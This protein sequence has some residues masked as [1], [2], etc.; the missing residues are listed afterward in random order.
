MSETLDGFNRIAWLYDILA[1]I[2]FGRSLERAERSLVA[3]VPHNADV[4]ILGGG[5]GQLLL[6]LLS[7]NPGCSVT[8]IE[9]SSAMIAIAKRR[10]ARRGTWKV[11]FFHRTALDLPK[12]QQFDVVV[13]NFFLD[14]FTA[15]TVRKITTNAFDSLKPDGLWL[16][17]DFVEGQAWWQRV[18]LKLMLG[19][20]RLTAR[21][22]ATHL[23]PWRECLEQLPLKLIENR[24]FYGGFV[25]ANAYQKIT[26]GP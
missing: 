10:L 3:M 13:T 5:S 11:D 4:L 22:E 24:L 19:F 23:P 14:I 20:F 9:A 1:R 18:I 12:G 6:D 17:C 8:Y 21:I 15:E 16:A 2:V 7:V 26:E 25:H